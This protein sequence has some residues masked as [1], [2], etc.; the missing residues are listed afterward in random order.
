MSVPKAEFY[1]GPY[2]GLVLNVEQVKKYCNMVDV[3][4]GDEERVFAMMPP[5]MDWERVICGQLDKN[6]PFA[7]LYPY[8]LRLRDAGAAF[9]FCGADEFEEAMEDKG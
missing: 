4:R 7:K 1:R 9:L 2:D 5:L 6:G 8:E 3:K